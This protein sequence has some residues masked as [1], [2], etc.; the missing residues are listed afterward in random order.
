MSVYN[1]PLLGYDIQPPQYFV[2]PQPDVTM[3]AGLNVF[4]PTL[5]LENGI[6]GATNVESV[7]GT[8]Q[9]DTI[10]PLLLAID[11]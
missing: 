6:I 10:D 1:G 2:A 3:P 11:E 7:N 8:E 5:P 4:I 9:V